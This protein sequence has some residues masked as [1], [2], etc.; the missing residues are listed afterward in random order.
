MLAGLRAENI[1]VKINN[2]LKV[3]LFEVED[4]YVSIKFIISALV[5]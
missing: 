4:E 2:S 5:K 1:T 3:T